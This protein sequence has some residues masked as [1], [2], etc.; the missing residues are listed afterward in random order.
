MVAR[1]APP[2]APIGPD[3][4]PVAP[5]PVVLVHG[6]RT[7]A[8]MWRRQLAA[9]DAAGVRAVAVDLPGHGG[10]TAEP[11]TL[12]GAVATIREGVDE[13][14]GRALV[15]G[16]SLGGYLAIEHRARH[17]EQSLG[18]VAASCSTPTSSGLRPAW[19][20]I[21]RWIEG[22]PDQGAWLNGTFVRAALDAESARDLGAGGFALR[23]MSQM[24]REL[25]RLGLCGLTG[26]PDDTM[27]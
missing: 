7:S 13:V 22:W 8:T 10:R 25:L 23:V 17:P 15:A 5:A 12:D 26:D 6:S 21:A 16:L 1:A 2:A 9:L 3:V 14:G 27:H 24:L 18:L 19:L 20:R 11:F 4:P